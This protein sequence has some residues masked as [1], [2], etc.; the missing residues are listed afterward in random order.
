MNKKFVIAMI[1]IV[2]V[3]ASVSAASYGNRWAT[4]ASD[5][6]YLGQGRTITDSQICLVTGEEVA[7]TRALGYEGRAFGMYGAV[8]TDADALCLVTGEAPLEGSRM[9]SDLRYNASQGGGMRWS[10]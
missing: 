1:L 8:G 9:G 2:V 4:D 10:R 6:R 5:T 3:V 7:A